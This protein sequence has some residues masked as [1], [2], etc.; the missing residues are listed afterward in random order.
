MCLPRYQLSDTDMA[1]DNRSVYPGDK[2]NGEEEAQTQEY[3]AQSGI[4]KEYY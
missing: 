1:G 4:R 2:S 3:G